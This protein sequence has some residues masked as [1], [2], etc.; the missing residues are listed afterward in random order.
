MGL[1]IEMTKKEVAL[2]F[3]FISNLGST[4]VA[5]RKAKR[6]QRKI[7][8]LRKVK[9]ELIPELDSEKPLSRKKFEK[10]SN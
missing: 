8:A 2:G 5:L 6:L 7:I 10:H 9:D 1:F 3:P 4:T